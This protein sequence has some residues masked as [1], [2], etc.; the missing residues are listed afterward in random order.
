MQ[1][2]YN[3]L[4]CVAESWGESKKI[5]RGGG[6]EERSF[7][8]LSLPLAP[9]YFF[10]LA[11]TFARLKHRNLPRKRLL[12]R[13]T[14][15]LVV[16][17]IKWKAKA[18]HSCGVAHFLCPTCNITEKSFF[19]DLFSDFSFYETFSSRSLIY[20]CILCHSRSSSYAFFPWPKNITY[21]KMT[22]IDATHH[23]STQGGKL[24]LIWSQIDK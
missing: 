7:L 10:A 6:G 11:P 24:K 1:V 17:L 3:H 23:K 13:L 5:E 8:L 12:R 14:F 2:S 15:V 18:R 20:P 22:K 19:S 4:T 9:L 16:I 21:Q